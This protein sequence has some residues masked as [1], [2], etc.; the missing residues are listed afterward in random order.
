MDAISDEAN[1]LQRLQELTDF[2]D[3]YGHCAIPRNYSISSM[4]Q[5][6]VKIQ[7]PAYN[8]GYMPEEHKFT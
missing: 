3:M 1:W 4:L 6:V 5:S 7:R 2:R 8:A